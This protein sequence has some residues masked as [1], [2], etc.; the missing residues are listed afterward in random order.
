MATTTA[1]EYVGN[2]TGTVQSFW[3]GMSIT[4][5]HLLRRPITTQY[6]DRTPVAVKDMLPARYRGFLEV[7]AA[8]CTGC[9]ACERACPIACIQI[10][11]DK[12]PQ[13]PKQRVVS[14]FDIDEAKCMFCGLCVEPCPTGSIQHTREFEGTQRSVRNLVFRWADPLAPFPVYKVEKG[15]A[16]FPRVPLG[17]LV[18]AHIDSRRWDAPA[19]KYLPPEPPRP[20]EEKKPAKAAAAAKPAAPAAAPAAGAPAAAAP[21]PAA[22]APAPAPAAAAPAAKPA[23]AG[24]APAAPAANPTDKA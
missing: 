24:A 7:D 23:D 14:Q 12:D 6:P 18:R 15:A 17:S 5:S 8:I 22:P 1:R 10:T 16:Y 11:L 21:A 3:H 2:I 9:Q 13:N 4:L 20:P 19:P